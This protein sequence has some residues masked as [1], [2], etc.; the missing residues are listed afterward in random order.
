[1]LWAWAARVVFAQGTYEAVYFTPA[2]PPTTVVLRGYVIGGVGWSFVPTSDLLV[3]GITATAPQVSF[4]A[5]TNR[6]LATFDYAGSF[7]NSLTGPSTDYQL[8]PSLLL[9]A[10]ETYYISAQHSNL[11]SSVNLFIY[12]RNGVE[13]ILPFDTSPYI[14][15]FA[16][17]YLSPSGQ[18][19]S[20]TSPA[21]E[22]ANYAF[23][24]P[25]FQF[26]VVPEPSLIQLVTCAIV[27]SLLLRLPR[28]Y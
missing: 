2:V 23:L 28:R 17:Y 10:G 16:S 3:T 20:P 9:S 19:S 22:N 24:G 6:L 8:V 14:S 27:V 7:G 18:W 4:W 12:S 11:N 5:Q 15:Q 26:Q 25:N 1:M 13:G 21:S